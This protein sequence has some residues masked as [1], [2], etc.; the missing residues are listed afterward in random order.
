MVYLRCLL[1]GNDGWAGCAGLGDFA[2]EVLQVTVMLAPLACLLAMGVCGGVIS[3]ELHR[4][5]L[6]VVNDHAK[7]HA[8]RLRHKLIELNGELHHEAERRT[9][10]WRILE[11]HKSQRKG[12][13][14]ATN[15]M[16]KAL[17]L[18]TA[19]PTLI[20]QRS[21]AERVP[22]VRHGANAAAMC[23]RQSGLMLMQPPPTG[24]ACQASPSALSRA[25]NALNRQH[26]AANS[27]VS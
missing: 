13:A 25:R 5:R 1:P 18:D 11:A 9:R 21:A 24:P 16:Q 8:A 10:L 7:H 20:A 12:V 17:R 19:H 3:M 22:T 6:R 27:L 4:R 2:L 23:N 26:A 14:D 15:A